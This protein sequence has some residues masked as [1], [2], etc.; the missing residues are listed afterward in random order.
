MLARE[1]AQDCSPSAQIKA[2]AWAGIGISRKPNRFWLAWLDIGA[3]RCIRKKSILSARIGM[4]QSFAL[5][6]EFG[7]HLGVYD[8]C[9]APPSV[10]NRPCFSYRQ[11][12]IHVSQVRK[13]VVVTGW[14]PLDHTGWQGLIMS[15]SVSSLPR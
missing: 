12:S 13:K 11:Q 9:V 2:A 7:I 4:V 1:G 3:R 6:L 5:S 14:N 15:I 8:V 10:L